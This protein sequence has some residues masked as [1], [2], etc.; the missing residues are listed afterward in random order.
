M[1]CDV[2]TLLGNNVLRIDMADWHGQTRYAIYQHFLVLDESNYYRLLVSGFSGNVA[3]DMSH[4]VGKCT[5]L[6]WPLPIRCPPPPAIPPHR[7]IRT[8][9]FRRR[10][11]IQC[12][13]FIFMLGGG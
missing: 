9:R 1:S 10:I 4:Q 12:F 8:K 13:G 2:T 3:D 5:P 6:P 11:E 7:L